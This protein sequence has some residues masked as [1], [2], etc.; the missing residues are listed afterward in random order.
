MQTFRELL[1]FRSSFLF[2]LIYFVLFPW[3]LA[4]MQQQWH[5]AHYYGGGQGGGCL[6][7][8]IILPC[9]ALFS[10]QTDI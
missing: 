3:Q 4:N 6:A 1:T 2:L 10:L 8:A 7:A 5:K 9:K